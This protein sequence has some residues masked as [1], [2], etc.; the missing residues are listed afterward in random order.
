[1]P[2]YAMHPSTHA[3]LLPLICLN[4]P[5]G[6]SAVEAEPHLLVSI[7]LL[8][9]SNRISQVHSC[10]QNMLADDWASGDYPSSAKEESAGIRRR[11]SNSQ[12]HG[13]ALSAKEAKALSTVLMYR[14]RLLVFKEQIV[15]DNDSLHALETKSYLTGVT[16]AGVYIPLQPRCIPH[17]PLSHLPC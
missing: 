4:G 2:C 7:H 1:M 6:A 17:K 13:R 5:C 8:P 9:T 14:Q 3:M 11:G 12:G 10:E 16:I 15:V